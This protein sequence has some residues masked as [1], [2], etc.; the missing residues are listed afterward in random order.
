M[1]QSVNLTINLTPAFDVQR[2]N[3]ILNQVKASMGKLGADI[4]PIDEKALNAS[5]NAFKSTASTTFKT[6]AKDGEKLDD[7]LK[8]VGVS[9]DSAS[10]SAG[11]LQKAFAFNQIVGSVQLLTGAFQQFLGPYQE[12]DRNLKNIGTLG[13]KNF[14]EF[15]NAAIDVA[16]S[17][18]DT[19]AGVTD[20]VYNAISAGAIPVKDGL[21]DVSGGMAFIETASK[22]AVAGLTDTNSAVQGLSANLNAYGQSVDQA[23]RFSDILF[24]TVNQGVTTI[25]QLNASLS[26]VIPTA[27]SMKVPFE[28]VTGALAAMTKQGIPTAQATTQLRQTLVELSKPGVALKQ[29]MDEAGVSLESLKAEGLQVTMQKLG[30]AMQ[31]AGK[32]ASQVFS[33]VEAANATLALSGNNAQAYADI[34]STYMTDAAGSTQR[35][36]EIANTGIGVQVQSIMNKIE[37]VAFKAFGAVGDGVTAMLGAA[38]QIAPMVATFAGLGQIVPPGAVDG[39][40]TM[41]TTLVGKLVPG[42]VTYDA[43]SKSS[44]INTQALSLS[45]IKNT[46]AEKANAAAKKASEIWNKVL[47]TSNARLVAAKNASNISTVK[48]TAS[49]IV[50]TAATKANNL[51]KNASQGALGVITKVKSALTASNI[52]NTSSTIANTAATKANNLAKSAGS[53]ISKGFLAVKNALTVANLRSAAA[54]GLSAAKTVALTVVKAPLIAATFAATAAQMGLNAAMAANPIGLIVLAVVGLVAGLVLLYKKVDAVRVFFDAAWSVIATGAKYAWEIIKKVWTIVAAVGSVVMQFL[55]TPF[56]IYWGILKAVG[57]AIGDFIGSIFSFGDATASA[58]GIIESL[59]TAFDW[60]MKQLDTMLVAIKAAQAVIES[61][62]ESTIGTIGALL[63]GDFKGAFENFTG[64]GK[65][66]MKAFGDAAAE[67]SAKL[68]FDYATKRLEDAM[69]E[70]VKVRLRIDEANSFDNLVKTYEDT[71]R[72]LEDIRAK[73]QSG[74]LTAAEQQ[75]LVALERQAQKVGSELAKM[76]PALAGNFKLVTNSAGEL[77]EVYDINV[78]KAKELG[79]ANREA[80]NLDEAIN[81]TSGALVGNANALKQ[82]IDL[83]EKKKIAYENASNPEEAAKLRKEWEEQSKVVQDGTE[84]LKQYLVEAAQNGQVSEAAIAKVAKALNLTTKEAKDMLVA[85]ELKKIGVESEFTEE[86]IGK[87]AAK[88]GVTKEKVVEILAQQKEIKKETEKTAQAAQTWGEFLK[89]VSEEQQKAKEKI[90]KAQL[91]FN[92]GQITEAEYQKR[93]TEGQRELA[94]ANADAEG[95]QKAINDLKSKGINLDTVEIQAG[96]EKEKTATKTQKAKESG[97]AVAL[98]EFEQS[99]QQA[100][101]EARNAESEKRLAEA[102][103]GIVKSETTLEREKIQAATATR[104]EAEKTYKTFEDV[105]AI[106]KQQYDIENA[107]GKVTKKTRDEYEEATKQL[108]EYKDSMIEA[109]INEVELINDYKID[110]AKAAKEREKAAQAAAEEA[111]K[112]RR[113]VAR[114]NLEYKV[115]IGVLPESALLEDDIAEIERQIDENNARIKEIA[116]QRSKTAAAGSA[117]GFAIDFTAN[118]SLETDRLKQQNDSL[119]ADLN[120]K[121]QEF[122]ERRT[123]EEIEVI[124]DRHV[125]ERELAI[126][127]AQKTY[128]AELAAAKGNEGKKYEAFMKFQTAKLAAEEDYLRESSKLQDIARIGFQDLATSIASQFINVTDPVGDA[129]DNLKKK[130]DKLNEV[131]DNSKALDNIKDQE[132][133]LEESFKNKELSGREYVQKMRELADKRTEIETETVNKTEEAWLRAQLGAAQA[134][135]SISDTYQKKAFDSLESGRLKMAENIERIKE[136]GGLANA[137]IKDITTGAMDQVKEF[138]IQAVKA[139]LSSFGAMLA[140]GEDV[141]VAFRKGFLK[142]MIEMAEQAIMTFIPQI[143]AVF[144]TMPGGWAVGIPAATAAIGLVY[145]ALEGAKAAIG[146]ATGAVD[147]Q[148]PGTPTSDSIPARISVHESVLT[149]KATLAPGNKELF[150]W[151]NKTGQPAYKFFADSHLAPTGMNLVEQFKFDQVQQMLAQQYALVDGIRRRTMEQTSQFNQTQAMLDMRIERQ[152]VEIAERTEM[153]RQEQV[154]TARV[155]AEQESYKTELQEQ[156]R[157][158]KDLTS[159]L[160]TLIA[161]QKT[162][163][164]EQR[165]GNYKRKTFNNID[166]GLKFKEDNLTEL[167][168]AKLSE[169]L[170]RS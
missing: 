102:R 103:A 63:K 122:N 121:N 91:D 48:N 90:L 94:K 29:I 3:A 57:S 32:S 137:S 138:G 21:A 81:R 168:K 152:R 70:G 99:K 46:I 159:K 18:P 116:E 145:T 83:L 149:A 139:S 134:L 143:Y 40:K 170:R 68:N 36:F 140:A 163:I 86:Q 95:G 87:L 85:E 148:G 45:T 13:V 58:K 117:L 55:I 154:I 47:S 118:L 97:F 10:K 52:K 59:G 51:A 38:T 151:L 150:N 17:V 153:V 125:R 142:T 2:F 26:N 126:Y 132:D 93:L 14:E 74:N 16:S 110:Q 64:A 72:K 20:A 22:L 161:D 67:E 115:R 158:N 30:V 88:Y 8:K 135:Q 101:W 124:E 44:I 157:A 169:N 75:E 119:Q 24:N 92:K 56:K 49:T 82:Q 109:Q 61:V 147:V 156:R 128:E 25:P 155:I 6:T 141:G 79:N 111:E 107:R 112:M 12:F 23:E 160:D 113:D 9:T 27:A 73:K 42:L 167:V 60:V 89:S 5:L 166:I 1:S 164:E 34:M 69:S 76:E 15:R 120:D 50:N 66:A 62:V 11:L 28:Q 39:V 4:K 35:A 37:A 65:N 100:D 98:K 33:S 7:T 129:I 96:K 84:Q 54:S 123:L 133:A 144:L 104:E 77:V 19:V 71:Q 43:A 53:G 127:N 165:R 106:A 136:N 105:F 114:K 41:A 162:L 78:A 131:Q 31:D 108:R 146:A 80:I 130:L